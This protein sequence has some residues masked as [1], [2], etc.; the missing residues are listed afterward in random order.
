MGAPEA[1]NAVNNAPVL[2]AHLEPE[3]TGS[4]RDYRCRFCVPSS[5]PAQDIQNASLRGLAA[6]I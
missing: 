4:F 6:F 2:M 3:A 1:R 5:S